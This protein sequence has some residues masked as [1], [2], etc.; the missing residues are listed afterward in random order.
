MQRIILFCIVFISLFQCILTQKTDEDHNSNITHNPIYALQ[1]YRL[2]GYLGK[3]VKA[4][5]L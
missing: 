1:Y 2:R 4:V 5:E 3:Y